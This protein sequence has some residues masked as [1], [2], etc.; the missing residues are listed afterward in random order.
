MKTIL[1]LFGGCSSEHAVSLESARAVLE[2]L[3]PGRFVPLA[4]GITR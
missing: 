2:A 4:V 3:D 1:L